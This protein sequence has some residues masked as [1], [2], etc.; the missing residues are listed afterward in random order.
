MAF[1]LRRGAQPD[2]APL[3]VLAD[4]RE[5]GAFFPC[6]AYSRRRLWRSRQSTP[7]RAGRRDRKWKATS[8]L[9]WVA[10]LRV[11]WPEPYWFR[12]RGDIGIGRLPQGTYG[13]VFT[14]PEE[15][16]LQDGTGLRV[17][18]HTAIVGAV[19]EH[20][21]AIIRHLTTARKEHRKPT[22]MEVLQAATQ[23]QDLTPRV[24]RAIETSLR[25][26]R[27]M[28]DVRPP[29][30]VNTEIDRARNVEELINILKIL[31][32]APEYKRVDGLSVGLDIARRIIEDGQYTIY[33]PD[34]AFY[35]SIAGGDPLVAYSVA[36]EDAKGAAGGAVGGAMAG[37]M[38]GG[39]GAIP[40]AALG[41][42]AGGAGASVAE[43]VGELWDFIFG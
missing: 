22:G 12:C 32:Y 35:Q 19:M 17:E 25:V 23:L 24:R 36:K 43:A 42:V 4:R 31:Q 28:A 38:A 37:S 1:G 40:G 2:G 3:G 15:D 18:D 20:P 10:T 21:L 34:S 27:T 30:E 33:S 39:G 41:A 6:P 26:L 13:I 8:F 5:G 11:P 7:G 9:R 14:P 16:S 29:S